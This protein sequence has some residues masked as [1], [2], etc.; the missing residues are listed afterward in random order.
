LSQGDLL[1]EKNFFAVVG[2]PVAHSK[3]PLI[4]NAA[5]KQKKINASYSAIKSENLV[6]TINEMRIGNFCGFSITIPHK[7]NAFK[8]VDEVDPLAEKIGA[9][10]TI[11]NEEG[12]LKGYNTD[13]IGAINALE[14]KIRLGGKAVYV[15]G[16]GGAARAIIAGLVKEKAVVTVY[17]RNRE[18]AMTLAE[19]FSCSCRVLQEID[20][21][22]DILINTTPVGMYPNTD[23][24]PIPESALTKGKIV[25]DIV[26]NPLETELLKK[27][28]KAKCK[29]IYGTE[30]FLEQAF[31]QFRLFTKKSPPKRI[32]RGILLK[33]LKKEQKSINQTA[34]NTLFLIGYRGTGKTCVGKAVAKKMK[35]VFV[36]ADELLVARVGKNIPEIFA[37]EGEN[38]FREYETDTLKEICKMKNVVVGCGGGVITREEN[39]EL[40]KKKGTICLLKSLPE[41][42]YERIYADKN[43][44]ALTDKDLYEE[45]VQ[46]LEKRKEMYET[47]KDF[48]IDST[49]SI[50]EC[51]DNIIEL[52]KKHLTAKSI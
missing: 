20:K 45:I 11:V 1:V 21:K 30:M 39:I 27:A 18:R 22:Y 9:I 46:M 52:Y 12:K 42:I 31:E 37:Q 36:D 33:Q 29:V 26:Y 14:G 25:F 8:L 13:C 47:A 15:I 34:K 4:F 38:K 7:I 51:A 3:S 5:F 23:E 24:M 49:K 19:E 16:S 17:A 32:M 48:E 28:K 43:R 2:N 35:R 50:D 44:P 40:M 6:E 41:K 10:N